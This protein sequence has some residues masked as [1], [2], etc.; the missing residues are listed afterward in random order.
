MRESCEIRVFVESRRRP[1][2]VRETRSVRPIVAVVAPPVYLSQRRVDVVYR[3]LLDARQS[4][5]VRETRRFADAIGYRVRVTD[6]GRSNLIAR[7][8][9][10]AF[11]RGRPLPVVLIVGA[12]PWRLLGGIAGARG[13]HA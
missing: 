1:W 9:R 4:D 7:A 10:R 3:R 8:L 11:L 5:V 12:C 2:Y 6:L 13:T